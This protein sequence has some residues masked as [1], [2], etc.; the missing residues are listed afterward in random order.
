MNR[1]EKANGE[2]TMDR[3]D[4]PRIDSDATLNDAIALMKDKGCSGVLVEL[5][6][7]R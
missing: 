5:A 1:R 2:V 4:L 7:D 6:P 3:I